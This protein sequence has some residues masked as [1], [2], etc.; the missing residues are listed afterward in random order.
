MSWLVL[1]LL[2]FSGL[3]FSS[4]FFSLHFFLCITQLLSCL[5]PSVFSCIPKR[6]ILP[7]NPVCSALT[8][9]SKEDFTQILLTEAPAPHG[10]QDVSKFHFAA[11]TQS[12]KLHQEKTTKALSSERIF[13]K[14][15]VHL[16]DVP[17]IISKE[18]AYLLG[19][20]VHYS[21]YSSSAL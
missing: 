18:T 8:A 12:K 5:W 2:S 13:W 16:Y 19:Y 11:S 1:T 17:Y 15:L 3:Q 10:H 6:G 9:G 20:L 7:G 21:S 14:E 4:C